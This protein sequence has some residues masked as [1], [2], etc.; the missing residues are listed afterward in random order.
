MLTG[1]GLPAC[2]GLCTSRRS[3]IASVVPE[4]SKV[5]AAHRGG[6]GARGEIHRE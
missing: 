4:Q 3:V 2:G 6:A 5:T 1:T